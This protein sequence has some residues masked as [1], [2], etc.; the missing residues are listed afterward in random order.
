MAFAFGYPLV[1]VVRDSFYAGSFDSP[2]WVGLDNYRGVIDDPEFRQSLVNNLK[3]LLG[4]PIMLGLGLAIAL[5]L[6][7]RIR[8]GA[9]VPGDRVPALRAAG[10]G[11][12]HRV[13]VPA[14]GERR[15][16]HARCATLHL[17]SL[18]QD[19]LGNSHLAIVSVGGLVVWQQL[20]FGV[21][22]FTAALLALPPETAEAAR[23][24]GAGWWSLQLRVLVPQIRPIIELLTV[25][26]VIT[27]LSWVFNY[28]YV[29]TSG[30]PGY[31]SS[32]MEL[33][34][35]RSFSNGA[36]GTAASV[37]VML[38]GMA[39]VLIALSLW[40]RRRRGDRMRRTQRAAA[41]S[42][43]S[44]GTRSSLIIAL[45]ALY[46]L[47]FIVSTALKTNADYQ[48]DPTG[49]PTHPTP[50]ARCA[51]SSTTSPCRAG[52]GTASSSPSSSVAVSTLIALLR[53]LRGRLRALPRPPD[54][55]LDERRADGRAAGHP[56]RADVRLHGRPRL[57]QPPAVGDH[58]LHGPARAVRDL[59][60]RR[61]SSAPCRRS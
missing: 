58:L 5:V 22:V 46:P 48:L 51:R 7:D 43:S 32:V 31:A 38:L 27:V 52:C 20:G 59:L 35:W 36:N 56:A 42:G 2:I 49:F 34:I 57:G 11:D 16:Q 6:N 33:Y 53:R 60:P 18:A 39:S 14:A 13:L 17:G 45:A 37:A 24:D 10:D 29:L 4:V 40:V 54:L 25:I 1:Q 15:A 26:Q 21:V 30:G 23:I 41:W 8:G 28:V 19:W 12:R 9:A 50:R 47:W 3:L 55:P 44:R 61:T